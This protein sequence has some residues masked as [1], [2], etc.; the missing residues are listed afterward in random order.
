M[1]AA[2]LEG[3][4]GIDVTA[5]KGG[6]DHHLSLNTVFGLY[7]LDL[8]LFELK[9]DFGNDDISHFWLNEE[10]N[11]LI[12]QKKYEDSNMMTI[13]LTIDNLTK[14]V[15]DVIRSGWVCR[16]GKFYIPPVK[17]NNGKVN[18]KVHYI[19]FELDGWDKKLRVYGREQQTP[20]VYHIVNLYQE[21]RE[22]GAGGMEFTLGLLSD[23]HDDWIKGEPKQFVVNPG[24]CLQ[25]LH[26][27][28]S[29]IEERCSGDEYYAARRRWATGFI[30]TKRW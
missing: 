19:Q 21:A 25:L 4:Q 16:E 12:I 13:T 3:S 9:S 1:I 18:D 8:Q 27:L 22:A 23:K 11:Q 14:E 26:S 28:P 6:D 29:L 7:E 17:G 30:N 15:I 24:P 2:Q 10:Q 20:T 5:Q